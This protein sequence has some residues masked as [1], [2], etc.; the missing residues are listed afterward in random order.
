MTTTAEKTAYQE[1]PA[2]F[3]FSRLDHPVLVADIT[4]YE[5][6]TKYHDKYMIAMDTRVPTED[7]YIRG[8]IV[9]FLTPAE[10]FA[11]EIPDNAA[12][13]FGI[14]QG[15]TLLKDGLGAYGFYL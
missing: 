6:E 14:W 2:I 4:Q 10:Y 15:L 8:N 7:G 12:N 5:A 13:N 1:M 3:D 9:A 11:L